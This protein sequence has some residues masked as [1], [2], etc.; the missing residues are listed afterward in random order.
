M[1]KKLPYNREVQ[2]VFEELGKTRE[3]SDHLEMKYMVTAVYRSSTETRFVE[4]LPRPRVKYVDGQMFAQMTQRIGY[5][6]EI[7]DIMVKD[8]P[9][10][11]S[12]DDLR[13][14][15]WIVGGFAVRDLTNTITAIDG[16]DTCDYLPATTFDENDLTYSIILRRRGIAY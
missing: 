13:P 12:E 10:K 8:I 5:Q 14:S 6:I 1:S 3:L 2:L 9:K 15:Y 11:Y 16:G 4:I 7:D